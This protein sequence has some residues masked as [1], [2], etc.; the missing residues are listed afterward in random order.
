MERPLYSIA[1]ATVIEG[2]GVIDDGPNGITSFQFGVGALTA[3]QLRYEWKV[4]DG[5][6]KPYT[7]DLPK[8]RDVRPALT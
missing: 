4:T 8:Y 1:G 3:G 7:Q 5:A 6:G 2:V